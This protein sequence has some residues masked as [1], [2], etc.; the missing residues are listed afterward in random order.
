[1]GLL[2]QSMITSMENLVAKTQEQVDKLT[3]I[4]ELTAM[5]IAQVNLV[6]TKTDVQK[7]LNPADYDRTGIYTE[8]FGDYISYGDGKVKFTVDSISFPAGGSG[9]VV[10]NQN[11]NGTVTPLITLTAGQS[12]TNKEFLITVAKGQTL[13]LYITTSQATSRAVMPAGSLKLSYGYLNVASDGG[14]VEV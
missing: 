8:Y 13:K 5:G 4:S 1:M 12:Q 6:P 3:T 11:V 2:F 7:V 10:L 9:S 14:L